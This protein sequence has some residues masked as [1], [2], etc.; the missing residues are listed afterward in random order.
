MVGRLDFGL[1][2][3][4]YDWVRQSVWKHDV[5]LRTNLRL[6]SIPSGW[7]GGE[8]W[9]QGLS[10]SHHKKSLRTRLPGGLATFLVA[11]YYGVGQS[12]KG[13]REDMILWSDDDYG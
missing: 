7:V 2:D 5:M 8:A 1:R 4:E 11:E 13:R 3:P 6:P 9:S 12:P 10:S